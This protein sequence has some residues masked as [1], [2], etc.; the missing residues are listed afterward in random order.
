MVLSHRYL[1]GLSR[2]S[3][4][5]VDDSLVLRKY[6]SMIG[7]GRERHY[8][9]TN[10]A[11]LGLSVF[12][13]V[14]SCDK[15]S[16]LPPDTTVEPGGPTAESRSA[17]AIARVTPNSPS[18]SVGARPPE[19]ALA[20]ANQTDF[21]SY[22]RELRPALLAANAE[23]VAR[24]TNFPFTVR[25]ELDDDPVRTIERPA[26]PAILRQLLAQDVGLSPEPE[27]LSRYL[28]RVDT[29]PPSAVAGKVARVASMQFALGSDGWRFVGAYLG[30]SE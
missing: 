6:P 15:V 1:R 13:T 28:K 30:E 4:L 7:F 29:V 14:C 9:R 17:E 22:W 3:G 25:G 26:F 16:P 2:N 11:D 21:I 8:R 10:W 12:I 5:C 19:N 24:L 18:K 23:A 27:P 20:T